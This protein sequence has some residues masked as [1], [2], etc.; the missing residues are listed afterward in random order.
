[1]SALR[2]RAAKLTP[3]FAGEV[4]PVHV[5]IYKRRMP[6]GSLVYSQWDGARWLLGGT[7][8]AI[9]VRVSD[10]RS[11]VQSIPWRGLAANPEA[12]K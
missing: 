10:C 6:I 3:W 2:K 12:A 11:M 1:M 4:K 8:I 9:A 5:G 7:T